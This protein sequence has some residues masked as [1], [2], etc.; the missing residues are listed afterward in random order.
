MLMN[1]EE[2]EKER[3]IDGEKEGRRKGE[4]VEG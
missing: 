3:W 4:E 2:G 1:E